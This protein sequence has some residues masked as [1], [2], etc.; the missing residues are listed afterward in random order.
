MAHWS[1][2]GRPTCGFRPRAGRLGSR[3]GVVL[4]GFFRSL[5]DRSH[6]ATTEPL[7]SRFTRRPTEV[8]RITMVVTRWTGVEVRALRTAA[9][10]I[11]QEEFAEAAGFTVGVVRKWEGRRGTIELSAR[12]ALPSR[13]L[14][15]ATRSSGSIWRARCSERVAVTPNMRPGSVSRHS[16]PRKTVRSDRCGNERTSSAEHSSRF[17]HEARWSISNHCAHGRRTLVGSRRPRRDPTPK[18]MPARTVQR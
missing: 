10:R 4:Q 5:G 16:R 11:T 1:P 7:R 13:T 17:P 12:I 3:R 2:R 6:A 9:L 18:R 15:G 8:G 14:C